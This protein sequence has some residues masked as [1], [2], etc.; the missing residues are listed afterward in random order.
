MGNRYFVDDKTAEFKQRVA[1]AAHKAGL[2]KIEKPHAVSVVMSFFL[3][4]PLS[5]KTIFPVGKP[6]LD[7]L[8]KGVLDAL[9]K[10]VRL[11]LRGIAWT[12]DSQVITL[13]AHKRWATD[14]DPVG[15]TVEIE[16]IDG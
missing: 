13:I 14:E 16:R 7:N 9:S 15:T 10:G 12:D 2:R 4:R 8:A 11:A 3:P 1:L 6:D 5:N